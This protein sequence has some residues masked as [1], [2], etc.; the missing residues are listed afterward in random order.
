ML[1]TKYYCFSQI[2]D[3]GKFDKLL[4][5]TRLGMARGIPRPSS[6]VPRGPGPFFTPRFPK[7]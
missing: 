7:E 6:L 4:L 5:Y 3:H 2:A 1:I